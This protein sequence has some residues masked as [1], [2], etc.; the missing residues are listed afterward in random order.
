[1]PP[2]AINVTPI[3]LGRDSLLHFNNETVILIPIGNIA[4][5]NLEGGLGA[6]GRET[7][8]VKPLF[9]GDKSIV[10]HTENIAQESKRSTL[11]YILRR[12]EECAMSNKPWHVVLE[13]VKFGFKFNNLGIHFF[14]GLQQY[15]FALGVVKFFHFVNYSTYDEIVKCYL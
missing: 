4:V 1:M 6:F 10:V 8:F 9:S 15:C 14:D 13:S 12:I 2:I 3:Q 11:F 7:E 5:G